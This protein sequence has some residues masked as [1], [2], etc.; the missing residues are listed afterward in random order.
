MIQGDPAQPMRFLRTRAV[1]IAALVTTMILS[2]SVAAQED[3]GRVTVETKT[4]TLSATN[5]SNL[6]FERNLSTYHWNAGANYHWSSQAWKFRLSELFRSSLI[7]ATEKFIKDEQNFSLMITRNLSDRLRIG[8]D[9]ASLFF[10]DN[11]AIGINRASIHSGLLGFTYQFGRVFSISPNVGLKMDTQTGQQDKGVSYR[12][13]SQ[14]CE[15]DLSGYRTNFY[16]RFSEDRIS[17]RKGESHAAILSIEKT[18]VQQS[19]GNLQVHFIRN[20]RD[21]YFQ[22][23]SLLKRE[24]GVSNNIEQRI[25]EILDVTN[26]FNYGVGDNLLFTFHAAVRHRGISKNINYKIADLPAGSLLDTDISEF[27]LNTYLQTQYRSD[28]TNANLRF[29]YGERDEEHEAHPFSKVDRNLF[30]LRQRNERRKNNSMRRT[31]LNGNI[32]IGLTSSNLLTFSSFASLLRYNTPAAENT[33]DRDELLMI[34]GFSDQQTLGDRLTFTLSA[35][36]VLN[37]IVYL[38]ADRS[39]N[40]NWN[41]V[42]RLSPKIDYR[43]SPRLRTTNAFEVLANYTVYDFEEQVFSVRSFSFR[44]FSFIDS[45]TVGLSRR[46]VLDLSARVKLYERGQFRWK[47]FRE[48]PV[49]Y[50]EDRTFTGQFRYTPDGK[51]TVALGFRYFAL[52]S[53]RY[54]GRER[55]FDNRLTNYGPT[56]LI[57][58][59]MKRNARLLLTGWYETQTQTGR[60]SSSVSNVAMKIALGL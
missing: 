54:E 3:Y 58:W 52:T 14:I 49:N 47:D 42:F 2:T 38:F 18:F 43:L 16:G 33:D 36:V 40:N 23:D 26:Q 24:F 57:E 27:K 34:F 21:F 17:P 20:R 19:R 60:S 45:T 53:F 30:E 9:A 22:G 29:A 41:R 39:A 10:S 50:F 12:L 15:L 46:I 11:R 32:Q 1:S 51:I 31:A 59:S 48:R 25:E 55:V 37:H 44:Q 5:E 4:D 6:S 13:T 56:C 35:D 28:R 8:F 7:R